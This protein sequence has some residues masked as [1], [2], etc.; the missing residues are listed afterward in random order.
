[1]HFLGWVKSLAHGT[2]TGNVAVS[3]PGTVNW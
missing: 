2:T 3:T 1:M